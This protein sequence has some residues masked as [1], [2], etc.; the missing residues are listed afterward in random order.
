MG[1]G[2]GQSGYNWCKTLRSQLNSAGLGNSTLSKALSDAMSFLGRSSFNKVDLGAVIRN[3]K[4]ER[5]NLGNDS[6]GSWWS[7]KKV[8][9][10]HD[11][12]AKGY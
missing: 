6:K 4:V 2:K 12:T 8:D 5:G 1:T 3:G 7:K 9:W 11:S 10:R